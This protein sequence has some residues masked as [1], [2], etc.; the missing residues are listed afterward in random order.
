MSENVTRSIGNQRPRKPARGL[1]G[2]VSTV[3]FQPAKFFAEMP[4]IQDNRQW[5]WVGLLLLII[6]GLNVV[7]QHEADTAS[8][9][10]GGMIDP[11]MGGMGMDMMGDPFMGDP[12]MSPDMGI[13]GGES[14]AD[15]AINTSTKW[16]MALVAGAG[17]VFIWFAQAVVLSQVSLFKGRAPVWSDN[18]QIVIWA[19]VPLGLMALFQMFFRWTGGEIGQAGLSGLLI[20]RAFYQEANPF[21]QSVLKALASNLTLFWVW[22]MVLIY[23]GARHVLGGQPIASALAVVMWVVV[24][25]AIPPIINP[26]AAKDESLTSADEFSEFP[27]EEFDDFA[28]FPRDGSPEDGFYEEDFS[29]GEFS[30][31]FFQDEEMDNFLPDESPD[32]V[33]EDEQEPFLEDDELPDDGLGDSLAESDFEEEPMPSDRNRNFPTDEAGE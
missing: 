28:P 25:V 7:Q 27:L 26:P 3:I 24:L 15:S 6:L 14:S 18:L 21:L 22:S 5:A 8:P 13:G 23:V 2:Q 19:A 30:E 20:E 10:D 31:D 12:F 4:R 11:M 16:E 32:N 9:T 29:Q 1:F 33:F 17:M